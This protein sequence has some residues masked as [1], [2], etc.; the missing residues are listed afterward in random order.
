MSRNICETTCP[1]CQIWDFQKWPIDGIE[2]ITIGAYLESI[3]WEDCPYRN[4]VGYG[5][6]QPDSWSWWRAESG[7]GTNTFST[8]ESWIREG[9]KVV[10]IRYT[11]K[12][13]SSDD[14]YRWAKLQCPMCLTLYAGWFVA[15]PG[16]LTPVE[17]P[18]TYEIYDLSYWH[19]FNDEPSK[20][21]IAD[22]REVDI[23]KLAELMNGGAS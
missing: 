9:V 14:Q 15:K 10:R 12:P 20:R 11:Y 21:D 6:R 13:I 1:E 4:E 23:R 18:T 3:G 7:A 2:L 5:F 16:Q 19:A 22:R 17:T 8:A